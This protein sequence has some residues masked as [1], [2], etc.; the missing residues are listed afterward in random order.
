MRVFDKSISWRKVDRGF[1]MI[2][3]LVVVAIIAVLLLVI[4]PNFSRHSLEGNRQDA[5]NA[6]T[7]TAQELERFYATNQKFS[8]YALPASKSSGGHYEIALTTSVTAYVITATAIGNQTADTIRS[9]RLNQ[10]SVQ[11]HS[12]AKSP[13]SFLSGWKD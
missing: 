8:G 1:S 6:L 7:N 11:Q 3:I 4:L 5:F 9:F 2:E 13:T 12:L 10:A